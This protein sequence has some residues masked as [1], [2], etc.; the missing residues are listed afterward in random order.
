MGFSTRVTNRNPQCEMVKQM[1]LCMVRPCEQE[2]KQPA[3]KVG[4]RK[5]PPSQRTWPGLIGACALGS[6]FDAR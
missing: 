1:R 3:E 6:Y 2:H 4:A 5:K